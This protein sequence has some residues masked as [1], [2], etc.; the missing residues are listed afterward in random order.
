[1]VTKRDKLL[2]AMRNSPT[3]VRFDDLASMCE[4]YFGEPRQTGSSH[5]VYA[6]PWEGDPRVNIQNRGGQAK[7]Y[8]VRQA[9]AAIDKLEA[10]QE[11]NDSAKEE[12]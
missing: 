9:L 10:M 7:P 8:Q 3:N 1:M 6:T 2:A 4:H 11:E 12:K 5:H